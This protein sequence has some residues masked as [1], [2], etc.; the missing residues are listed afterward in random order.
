MKIAVYTISLNEE[1]HIERW[2][3]SA[4]DADVML[5]ADTGSNDKTVEIAK[6]NGCQVETV[7]IKPW[8]FDD[9]RNVS[10]ALLPHDITYCIALDADEVLVEG[11]RDHLETIP[12]H[13]TR[14]RYKY[15]WSWNADGSPGVVYSGDKIHKRFGYRWTHPVHEV[16]TPTA[17]EIQQFCGLEIHHYPDTKKPRSY[18]NLLELAIKERPM[19]DR[20][21][22]YL[23]REYF[24]VGQID[25]AIAEFKRHINLETAQWP[26][27]K[28]RSMRYLAQCIPDE[29][30]AWLY[31]AIAEDPNRR[32][33]WVDLAMHYYHKNDW[34]ACLSAGLKALT[35]TERALDYMSEPNA[36]GYIPYDLV[37]LSYYRLGFKEKAVEYGQLALSFDPDDPRLQSNLN[38]YLE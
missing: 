37:A 5:I 11:W 6:D 27:E 32:E 4:K 26:A 34:N 3:Q 36:W 35:Y 21:S 17:D 25:K 31:R 30:E 16:I 7:Y 20:N 38:F 24:Y 22:H 23:A 19:D 28:A 2:A 14:P 9:A 29:A 1:K 15:T 12:T 8:R 10:L 18:L 13:V 33:N